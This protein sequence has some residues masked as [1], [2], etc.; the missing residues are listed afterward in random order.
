M[1]YYLLIYAYKLLP[2]FNSK[3]NPYGCEQVK[4]ASIIFIIHVTVKGTKGN[5]LCYAIIALKIDIA[6]FD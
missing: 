5:L 3:L 1:T 2:Q 6:S 4:M